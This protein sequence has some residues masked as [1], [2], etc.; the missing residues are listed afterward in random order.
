MS[1]PAQ[2]LLIIFE[3]E[4]EQWATY[5]KSVF[6][7]STREENICFYNIGTVSIRKEEFLQLSQYKCKLLI[8]TKGMLDGLCQIRKFFLAR[9]LQPSKSVVILLCGV[10]SLS[11]LFDMVPIGS[12]C[13]QISSDQDSKEYLTIVTQ[14]L[15]GTQSSLQS[16][17]LSGRAAGKE[18]KLIK[19]YSSESP[20]V[21]SSVVVLPTRI[22]CEKPGE[23]FILLQDV[24]VP[25]DT[26]VEFHGN[27]Q[28]IKVQPTLWNEKTLCV[29]ALAFPPGTVNVT[30]YNRGTVTGKTQVQYY[31]TMGEIAV[32]LKK[33]ADP[34]NF[35]WQAFQISSTEK[36][37]Q[38][39]SS[40]L[41][42]RMPT[43]GFGVLQL[44]ESNKGSEHSDDLPTLLHFAA[45]NGLKNLASLLLQC[46]GAYQAIKMMNKDGDNPLK[47]A[48]KHGHTEMQ[49]HMQETLDMTQS[50]RNEENE[51]S[52]ICGLTGLD[53]ANHEKNNNGDDIQQKTE[54]ENV[55]EDEDEDEDPYAP[56]GGNDEEYDT[57]LVS[58]KSMSIINRPPA[59]TPRPDAS[60]VKEDSTPFIAQVFQKK[61]SQ[62]DTGSLYSI[63]S[64]QGKERDNISSTY[65]SFA[66]YQHSGLEELIELQ[67]KVKRGSLTMDEALDRFNEW[68]KMQKGLDALQQVKLQQL[69]ASIINNREDDDNVYD[70]INIIHHTPVGMSDSGQGSQTAEQDFYSKPF[71]GHQSH[72]FGKSD[73]R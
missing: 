12:D 45:K 7:K 23:L 73:K 31:N 9:V 55:H 32:L 37:D 34:I 70:K 11:S 69:R 57:I 68:Q 60:P 21:G 67:E 58:N 4:A 47:L 13:F 3:D 49:K 19:K 8:L 43:G 54:E 71:K 14:I 25:K 38:L 51:D 29:K 53:P 17:S 56:L 6:L 10:D 20:P 33:A 18:V 24:A 62:A 35:M 61:M 30:V 66:P 39:L 50:S 40:S 15:Q 1:H 72:F 36:L 59:P 5:L 42:Q 48:E 44:D 65:D 64:R 26:V 28:K 52:N 22:P 63:S 27:E 16:S 46:P 41:R 2:D